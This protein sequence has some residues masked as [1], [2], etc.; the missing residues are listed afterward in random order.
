MKRNFGVQILGGLIELFGVIGVMLS[1][2][3]GQVQYFVLVL[4]LLAYFTGVFLIV[5]PVNGLKNRTICFF[6]V[7]CAPIVFV[8]SIYFF[9]VAERHGVRISVFANIA[10]SMIITVSIALVIIKIGKVGS[11]KN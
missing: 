2:A 1:I 6:T 7:A 9:D 3:I 8:S 11:M 10:L 5:Y 4:S